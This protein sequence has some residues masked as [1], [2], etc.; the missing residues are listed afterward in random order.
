MRWMIRRESV[1]ELDGTR[2]NK[3]K[4]SRRN[5]VASCRDVPA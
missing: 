3:S 5:G 4:S 1:R 2:S